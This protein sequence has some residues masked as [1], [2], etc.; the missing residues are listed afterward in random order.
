[1]KL[2]REPSVCLGVGALLVIV[3]SAAM[4]RQTSLPAR[5]DEEAAPACDD[6]AIQTL[7]D[8]LG[9]ARLEARAYTLCDPLV[10]TASMTLE[11]SGKMTFLR[12]TGPGDYAVYI[13]DET[14]TN[15]GCY[16]RD[17]TIEDGGLFVA[18][19]APSSSIERVWVT[20]APA[21]GVHV[22]AV[23][24]WTVFRDVI[25]RTSAKAGFRV[26][27]SGSNSGFVFD[28]CH[29]QS[30]NGAGMVIET[31]GPTGNIQNISLRDCIFEG[32]GRDPLQR[33]AEVLLYGYV[34]Y[35][36]LDNCWIGDTL[37]R[38]GIRT[39]VSP[40]GHFVHGLV[41]NNVR[42]AN[43]AEALALYKCYD[44][45]VDNII[46]STP[47]KIRYFPQASYFAPKGLLRN[48]GDD[49]A[50]IVLDPSIAN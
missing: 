42:M 3:A 18:R 26:A 9:Y 1:M 22:N 41:L 36:L 33:D 11:G 49:T 21:D 27:T 24:Q 25:S 39:K 47:P 38:Y 34:N 35:V 44:C 45:F 15:F 6:L 32:N 4:W 28:H 2:M 13:G 40:S 20:G 7:L 19:G 48:N 16:L 43:V 5:A 14:Q 12:W 23:G 30:N 29:S 50:R 8:T 46:L 17:L 10:L 37:H 31:T